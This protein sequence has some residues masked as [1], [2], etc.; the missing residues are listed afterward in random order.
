MRR[1]QC[2]VARRP[3]SCL[4]SPIPPRRANAHK[5]EHG[6]AAPQPLRASANPQPTVNCVRLHSSLHLRVRVAAEEAGERNGVRL[7]AALLAR[8]AHVHLDVLQLGQRAH[9]R[10]Q[11]RRIDAVVVAHEHA[12]RRHRGRAPRGGLARGHAN[13]A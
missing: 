1:Q 6:P 11:A 10:A 2:R 3:G 9:Q 8:R 4:V 7:A 5:R 13:Q 12:L